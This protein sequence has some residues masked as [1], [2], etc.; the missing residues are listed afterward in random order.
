L[1]LPLGMLRPAKR[2]SAYEITN[3]KRLKRD[4]PDRHP[5]RSE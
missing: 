1:E 2:T 4:E 3:R 5:D